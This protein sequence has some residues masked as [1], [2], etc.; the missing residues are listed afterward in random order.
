MLGE[1]PPDVLDNGI[2]ILALSKDAERAL[3]REG[4]E[5]IGTLVQ[6]NPTNLFAVLNY[7][8]ALVEE[9]REALNPYELSLAED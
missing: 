3:E 4:V 5:K 9:V 1:T 7:D 2:A 8:W 6:I